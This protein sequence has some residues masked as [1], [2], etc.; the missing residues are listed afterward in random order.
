MRRLWIALCFVA[1]LLYADY[2]T[3]HSCKECHPDIYEEYQKSWHS[4]TWFN[5]ELHRKVAQ[6][7]PAYDCGRCH[8]PA[9]KNLREMSEGKAWPDPKR[10]EQRDAVSCYYCHQIAYVKE[11]HR[12]NEITLARQAENYKP[13]LYGALENPDTS[14]KHSMVHSPIY[15]RYACIGC[16]S[17][18]RNHNDVLI[19]KATEPGEGS[20]S[21]I[22]CHMPETPGAPEKMNKKVR[23]HHHSHHFAGI[24]DPT[25]RSK[26]VTI[27]LEGEGNSLTVTLRNEM[28]HP[29]IIH[30]ARL[31]YLRLRIFRDGR[32]IWQ[33]YEKDPTEDRQGSFYVRFSDARGKEA[34][35]PYYA[36]KI[37]FSNNLEK[38]SEKKLH[39]KVPTLRKNDRMVAEMFV[40][41]AKPSCANA[42]GVEDPELTTP[43][44]MKRVEKVVQ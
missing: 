8:M 42:A 3:N 31:K 2:M 32:V 34:G 15:E 20:E 13:T 40:V 28:G 22:R 44:L 27:A 6:K 10:K 38:K 7:V 14:D 5:D 16:H 4:R 1:P 41:L 24:H 12:F 30:P 43:L 18:K 29:L 33:N 9:A 19:F 25:M 11:A 37:A 26:G 17:H 36:E 39:Y 35:I 21:C 23:S